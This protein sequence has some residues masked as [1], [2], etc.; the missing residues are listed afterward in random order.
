M[1]WIVGIL[2]VAFVIHTLVV[3][4]RFRCAEKNIDA[5][6]T[7]DARSNS[8]ITKESADLFQP[9]ANI[10]KATKL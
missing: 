10:E 3:R 5:L 2:I 4:E 8:R 7:A 9:R 6:W 1:D